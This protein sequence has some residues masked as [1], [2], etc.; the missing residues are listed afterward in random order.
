MIKLFTTSLFVAIALVFVSYVGNF[1]TAA[2]ADTSKAI[3]TGD[4]SHI[5]NSKAL[6][7][8]SGKAVTSSY[9]GR[10]EGNK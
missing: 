3:S 4:A 5:Q 10:L 6:N 9:T 8:A 7:A 1:T 2:V